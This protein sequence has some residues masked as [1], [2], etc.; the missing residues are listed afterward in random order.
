MPTGRKPVKHKRDGRT[1][2]VESEPEIHNCLPPSH[3]GPFRP[4]TEQTLGRSFL[5]TQERIPI[6]IYLFVCRSV[7]LALRAPETAV[8]ADVREEQSVSV[9]PWT[10]GT[11]RVGGNVDAQ[12]FFGTLTRTNFEAV[13]RRTPAGLRGLC[14]IIGNQKRCRGS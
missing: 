4:S 9:K 6:P 5:C 12:D 8:F 10:D 13:V 2:P 1:P 3:G 14:I 11:W 7:Q